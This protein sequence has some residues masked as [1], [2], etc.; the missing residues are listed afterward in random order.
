M[1]SAAQLETKAL[2]AYV[3]AVSALTLPVTVSTQL[4]AFDAAA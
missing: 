1:V 3:A 4:M 2:S